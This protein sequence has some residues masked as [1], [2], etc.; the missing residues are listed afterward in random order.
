MNNTGLDNNKLTK[1]Y[2][3]EFVSQ[4]HHGWLQ[5]SFKNVSNVTRYSTRIISDLLVAVNLNRCSPLTR[6]FIQ[7][8]R[9]FG[10]NAMSVDFKSSSDSFPVFNFS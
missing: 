1:L 5:E 2:I 9:T 4:P 8:F 10:Y 3:P 6:K 7:S